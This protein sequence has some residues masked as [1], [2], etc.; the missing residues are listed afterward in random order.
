MQKYQI[1]ICQELKEGIQIKL[2]TSAPNVPQEQPIALIT[3]L[4]NDIVAPFKPV[5]ER[6]R[7][8][9]RNIT[10]FEPGKSLPRKFALKSDWLARNCRRISS[11]KCR[12]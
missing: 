5:D 12:L 1:V 11:L 4:T 2:C 7:F 8:S 6:I 3:L 9:S 10:S